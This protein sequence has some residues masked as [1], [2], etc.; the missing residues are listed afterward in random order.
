[1]L[2]QIVDRANVVAPHQ[3]QHAQR[4]ER[5]LA[6]LEAK[7]E[8]YLEQNADGFISRDAL[9]DK[10]RAVDQELEAR[11]ALARPARPAV[12][13]RKLVEGIVRSFSRFPYRPFEDR[14]ELLRQAV[15]EIVVESGAIPRLTLSGGFLG[16][17]TGVKAVPRS[18]ASYNFHPAPIP[19]LSLIFPEPVKIAA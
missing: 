14:R 17:I 13:T 18:S 1:L 8:R 3:E 12:E 7:R 15:T 4:L 10:L 2:R 6:K 19:D 11:R 16:D 9:R 5:E